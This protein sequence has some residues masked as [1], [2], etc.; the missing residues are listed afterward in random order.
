MQHKV[1]RRGMGNN[2]KCLQRWRMVGILESCNTKGGLGEGSFRGLNEDGEWSPTTVNWEALRSKSMDLGPPN[3]DSEGENNYFASKRDFR[4]VEA[5]CMKPKQGLNTSLKDPWESKNLKRGRSWWQREWDLCKFFIRWTS[6]IGECLV[7]PGLCVC[8]EGEE[9]GVY[10]QLG[11]QM[12]K[13]KL[14]N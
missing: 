10:T 11:I 4:V 1:C 7:C 3:L 12:R 2:V 14:S 5:S 13:W 6:Y 8:V 9:G